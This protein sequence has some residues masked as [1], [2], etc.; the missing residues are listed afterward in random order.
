MSTPTFRHLG[1]SGS[2]PTAELD[3]FPAPPD[4]CIVRFT[5]H[6]LT[7]F[8]PV[9]N[10]PDLSTVEIAYA[11]DELCIE[12]KSLKLYFWSFRDRGIFVEAL[13]SEI[14]RHIFDAVRPWDVEVTVTQQ[15]RGGIVTKAE[16]RIERE[17]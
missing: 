9:T 10:Q 8:C 6:E 4:L 15:V 16:A 5:T 2:Q 14:A 12:T 7:S 3:T 1:Q 17:D 11:P 13:A